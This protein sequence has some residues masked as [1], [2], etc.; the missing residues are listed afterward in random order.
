MENARNLLWLREIGSSFKSPH[1]CEGIVGAP[2]FPDLWS[3][4]AREVERSV[5]NC[6]CVCAESRVSLSA[7]WVQ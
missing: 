5:C 3:A 7:G 1:I 4:Q 6:V 2:P